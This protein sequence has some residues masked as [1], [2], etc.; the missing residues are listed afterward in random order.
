MYCYREDSREATRCH[1]DID[2]VGVANGNATFGA[3][4]KL[5]EREE[6]ELGYARVHGTVKV[7]SIDLLKVSS[8]RRR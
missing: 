1:A 6:R 4:R 7:Q 2:G 8:V 3:C 5:G